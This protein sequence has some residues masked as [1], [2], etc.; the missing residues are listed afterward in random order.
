MADPQ[1]VVARFYD[2]VLNGKQLDLLSEL[3][4]PDFVEHG[5]P[6]IDGVEPLHRLAGCAGDGG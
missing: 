2:K 5:V 6:P 4:R 1:A 3:A